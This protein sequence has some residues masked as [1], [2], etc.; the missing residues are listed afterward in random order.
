MKIASP[1]LVAAVLLGGQFVASPLPV[2]ATPECQLYGPNVGPSPVV[3]GGTRISYRVTCQGNHENDAT[4]TAYAGATPIFQVAEQTG[5]SGAAFHARQYD[6][7]A[8]PTRVCLTV[9]VVQDPTVCVP[10]N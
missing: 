9:N 3:P 10:F 8:T 4:L 7:P 1:L 5:I 2:S 6:I